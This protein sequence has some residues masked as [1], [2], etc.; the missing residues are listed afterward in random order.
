MCSFHLLQTRL[1]IIII[2]KFCNYKLI[3]S[4]GWLR[5]SLIWPPAQSRTITKCRLV[6]SRLCPDKSC[7][8][9]R[10][11][12]SQHVWKASSIPN[13]PQGEKCFLICS[14]KLRCP[15]LWALPLI[16]LPTTY[17]SSFLFISLLI[18]DVTLLL[19]CLQSLFSKF[20]KP[21]FLGLSLQVIYFCPTQAI[22]VAF[23]PMLLSD[24]ST[25]DS[26]TAGCLLNSVLWLLR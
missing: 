17:F 18:L 5:R 20:E 15:N 24:L 26:K 25:R 21:R 12:L 16:V 23:L 2:C 1:Y 6:G 9:P 8:T 19:G 22:L 4:G 14:L 11:K 10:M 7:K 13:C 3:L